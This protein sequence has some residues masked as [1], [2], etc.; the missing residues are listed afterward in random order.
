M[1]K[2]FVISVLTAATV[3][4]G[5]ALPAKANA[6]DLEMLVVR[7]DRSVEVF[8]AMSAPVAVDAFGLPAD[9]LQRDDGSVHFDDFREGTWD[10]GDALWSGLEATVEGQ[11]PLFEAMS[12]MVHPANQALPLDNPVDGYIAI[13]VCSVPTPAVPPT[14]SD[15]RLYNG[16]IAY[17]DDAYGE[18]EIRLPHVGDAPVS[19]SVREFRDH[20][21]LRQTDLALAGDKTSI[22]LPNVDV[23]TAGLTG[24]ALAAFMAALSAIVAGAAVYQ[25]AKSSRKI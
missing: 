18:I 14:L 8:M 12:L 13:A 1:F 24:W 4:I 10:I 2:R 17:T 22:V 7:T 16:V 11:T 3:A 6:T 20:S 23:K 15:L 21:F 9:L 25:R 19:I 5:L